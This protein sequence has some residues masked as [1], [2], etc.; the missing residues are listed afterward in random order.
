MKSLFLAA[1][2]SISSFA[3]QQIVLDSEFI[4]LGITLG[5]DNESN[6]DKDERRFQLIRTADTPEVIEVVFQ[7]EARNKYCLSGKN[8]FIDGR[9]L[10]YK[11]FSSTVEYLGK[12][13]VKFI[14]NFKEATEIEQLQESE[15]Q[16][17]DMQLT[18][19]LNGYKNYQLK[20]EEPVKYG[21]KAIR[22]G[23]RYFF[24]GAPVYKI[25]N[26]STFID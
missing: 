3:S 6:I 2:F 22:A 15:Q 7:V 11:C 13:E 5:S 4:D 23:S 24:F 9:Y 12:E 17:L 16:V 25:K 1:I 18:Y 21:D 8:V 20:I 26:F 19:S 14:L 10:G